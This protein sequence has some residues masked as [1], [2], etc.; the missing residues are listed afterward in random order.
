MHRGTADDLLDRGASDRAILALALNR[1]ANPVTGSNQINTEI[2]CSPGELD[3]IAVA[4]QDGGHIPLEF[5]T[6][7]GVDRRLPT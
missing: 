7:H 3:E 1:S 6:A 5:H 2:T 4:A